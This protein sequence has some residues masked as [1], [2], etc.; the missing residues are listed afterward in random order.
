MQALFVT[1]LWS[2]SWVFIK[3]GLR[4]DIPALTFA[5]LRYT[6]AFL[7]LLPLLLRRPADVAAL[8]SLKRT[9]WLRLLM[10]GLL[11]YTITQGAQFVGLALLPSIT[12]NLLLTLT[13]LIVA[14][15]GIAL[16]R[17]APSRVQWIGVAVYMA[18]V[19]IY[20]HP[21]ALPQD[22][23]FGIGVVLGGVL[24]GAA[25]SLLG[26]AVNRQQHLSP[27]V[28]TVTTMGCGSVVLLGAGLLI[29]GLPPISF[30]SWLLI[31]WLAVANTAFAFTLWNHTLREL[32]A[33]ESS[34]I[35]NMMM[36]QIP[37]LAWLFLGEEISLKS[38][39][40]FAVAGVGIL[41]VQLRNAS[42]R[43]WRKPVVE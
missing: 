2:T 29:Q 12:V 40:G 19:V 34:V 21:L 23:L 6:L 25:A 17:E 10:L 31:V 38:G 3:I 1:F 15:L 18:G 37:V 16:L 5:G 9:R 35:N 39:I 32:S 30:T 27:L 11:M 43:R 4:D 22:Q 20:F 26:R 8:R 28:V 24:A 36:V 7:C 33:M 14:V 41:I 42:F 13:A